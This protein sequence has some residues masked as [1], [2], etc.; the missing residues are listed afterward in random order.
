MSNAGAVPANADLA[1]GNQVLPSGVLMPF[2]GSSAP[3]GWLICDGAPVSRSTYSA[4]FTAI[5]TTYGTG[6]G[7][8]TFNLPDTRSRSLMG[9]ST[10][11]NAGAPAL[12]TD[13]R[14]QNLA[15]RALGAKLGEQQHA[16]TAAESGSPAHAHTA[17]DSGHQHQVGPNSDYYN[18]SYDGDAAGKG[19]IAAGRLASGIGGTFPSTVSGNANITVN[20]STAVAASSAHDVIHPVIV[21]NHI[22]KI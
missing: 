16:L 14:G 18:Y 9:A 8:T 13:T 17:S 1:T 7:S 12:G 19:G 20:N 22:I 15:T 21:V 6:D 5:S 10:A 4:L 2:A 3:G 11:V